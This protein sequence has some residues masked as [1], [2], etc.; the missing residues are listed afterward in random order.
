MILKQNFIKNL[1]LK[2]AVLWGIFLIQF[3]I[4]A[5]IQDCSINAGTPQSIC[6]STAMLG[7]YQLNGELPTNFGEG[8]TITW[9]TNTEGVTILSPNIITPTII[10]PTN[11]QAGDQFLFTITANCAGV[12]QPTTDDV[13][14]TILPN[15]IANIIEEGPILATCSTLVT[16]NGN[17]IL[18]NE[19]S[20][21][22]FTG[23]TSISTSSLQNTN[24]LNLST[25]NFSDLINVSY[26]VTNNQGCSSS[27]QVTVQFDCNPT[28]NTYII[29][30]G[31]QVCIIEDY[32]TPVSYT[33]NLPNEVYQ[34]II[35]PNN[36][37]WS[38]LSGPD[39]LNLG[40]LNNVDTIGESSINI[41]SEFFTESGIYVFHYVLNEPNYTYSGDVSLNV[42]I[43]QSLGVNY[44]YELFSTYAPFSNN[45]NNPINSHT[46]YYCTDIYGFNINAPDLPDGV[47]SHFVLPNGEIV[48]GTELTLDILFDDG[49]FEINYYIFEGFCSLNFNIKFVPIH[50]NQLNCN[51]IEF[52][53]GKNYFS[54]GELLNYALFI[55]DSQNEAIEF[56]SLTLTNI[57]PEISF[58]GNIGDIQNTYAYNMSAGTY[59]FVA[60]FNCNSGYSDWISD[61]CNFVECTFSITVVGLP[62]PINAGS[63]QYICGNNAFLNGNAPENNNTVGTWSVIATEPSTSPMPTINNIHNPN[64]EITNLAENTVYTLQWQFGN[65]LHPECSTQDITTITTGVCPV[66]NPKLCSSIS[67]NYSQT[68]DIY[69]FNIDGV[70]S[71]F[72]LLQQTWD[73]GDGTTEVID[74][75]TF[76]SHNYTDLSTT[77]SACVTLL[78]I[79]NGDSTFYTCSACIE[80]GNTPSCN[81]G[82]YALAPCGPWYLPQ[83]VE[84]QPNQERL[85][86]NECSGYGYPIYIYDL[87]TDPPTAILEA[88]GFSFLWNNGETTPYIT[89]MPNEYYSVTITCNVTGETQIID[90]QSVCCDISKP[91]NLHCQS[92]IDE[93]TGLW[94]H[95]IAW[96]EIPGASQYI[97]NFYPYH[98]SCCKQPTSGQIGIPYSVTVTQPYYNLPNH[99][100]CFAYEVVAVCGQDNEQIAVS[101]RVCYNLDD[102][103]IIEDPTPIDIVICCDEMRYF[104]SIVPNPTKGYFGVEWFNKIPKDVI[105]IIYLYDSFGNAVFKEQILL[106]DKIYYDLTKYKNGTYYILL[107]DVNG[108]KLDEIKFE[109]F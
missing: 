101:D 62:E 94:F 18:S 16:I 21:W 23:G 5:Q 33:I 98:A 76:P 40:I 51:N 82:T 11:T 48:N 78:L 68:D 97:I 14:I 107:F 31:P 22:S 49:P 29:N 34:Y 61:T 46:Y 103:I 56:N 105:G 91:N 10:F 84:M 96:D 28:E 55:E 37:T 17:S 9:S 90:F 69:S 8:S 41:P 89:G 36:I 93:Q 43:N 60:N 71:E 30:S 6:L 24:F 2:G 83:I 1:I 65:D 72:T 99:K 77:I 80:V 35:N 109:K 81:F 59:T 74:G 7:N 20:S 57:T 85:N 25:N 38:F 86:C 70:P 100:A 63:S 47:P 104:N 45:P 58:S 19:N 75:S 12:T 26:L 64:S 50:I 87:T 32:Y 106:G 88:D 27:D 39:S 15:P 92:F 42:T 54:G 79:N 67:L 4:S 13:L 53:C 52:P 102:C 44:Q 3:K 95:Q 66:E 73:F 108:K